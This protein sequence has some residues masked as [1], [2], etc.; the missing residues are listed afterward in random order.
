MKQVLKQV[1]KR[2]DYDKTY[3]IIEVLEKNG[4]ITI[5]DVMNLTDRTR[6]TAWRYLRLLKDAG[7]LETEGDTNKVV[8]LLK[9]EFR[10]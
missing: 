10:R 8:Y 5:Q 9:Q 4:R 6:T 3:P 7:V 1:L 2:S